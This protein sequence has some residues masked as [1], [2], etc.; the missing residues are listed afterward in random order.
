MMKVG[1]TIFKFNQE[2][3]PV[4]KLKLAS[5]LLESFSLST[6]NP[7]KD[8]S[9]IIRQAKDKNDI[10]D[11][12]IDLCKDINKPIAYLNIVYSY[13]LKGTKYSSMYIEYCDKFL[14][15][16]IFDKINKRSTVQQFSNITTEKIKLANAFKKLSIDYNGEYD[17]DNAMKSYLN[18]YDI[19]PHFTQVIDSLLNEYRAY[20]Y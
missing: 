8:V 7:S 15:N 2:K 14:S 9:D 19:N 10:L 4:D 6:K 12:I 17:F 13:K 11:N 18:S 1:G 16:P 3:E 20:A 5:E